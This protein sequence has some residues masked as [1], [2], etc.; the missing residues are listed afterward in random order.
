MNESLRN[1]K[2]S[3]DQKEESHP[4][5]DLP[6]LLKLKR[7]QDLWICEENDESIAN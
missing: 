4:E 1:I 7:I 6:K 5:E 2:L 3:S